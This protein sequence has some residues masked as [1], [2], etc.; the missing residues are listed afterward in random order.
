MTKKQIFLLAAIFIGFFFLA[1][2]GLWKNY[3]AVHIYTAEE[4]NKINSETIPDQSEFIYTEQEQKDMA[5]WKNKT[6][7]SLVEDADKG[8]GAALWMIGTS[9]LTGSMG[10]PLNVEFADR[11]YSKSASVGFAPSIDQIF[12][13]YVNDESNIFL[14]LV[15]KNLTI[16]FGHT[17]FIKVYHNFRDKIIKNLGKDGQRIINEI[18][19]IAMQKKTIILKNQNHIQDRQNDKKACDLSLKDITDKDY[20]YDSDYWLDVYNGDNENLDFSE[21]KERDKTYLDKLH[22]IYYKAITSDN[23]DLDLRIQE[24]IKEMEKNLYS[25]SEIEMLRKQAKSQA[26]KS[27]K[28]ICKIESEG[29]EAKNNLKIL[30]KYK[31]SLKDS[32]R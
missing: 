1:K 6:M 27:Y 17:E 8:N 14:G 10:L 19:R 20:Q 18:E 13:K 5:K 26:K 15:Y 3:N 32:I 12:R 29:A 7:D 28:L 25:N 2:V 21:V 16:S 4:Q 31:N 23:K 9:F 30:E 24:I 22:G 11:Y